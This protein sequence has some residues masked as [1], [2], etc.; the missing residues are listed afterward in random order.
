M[1]S[2]RSIGCHFYLSRIYLFGGDYLQMLS[3]SILVVEGAELLG[4]GIYLYLGYGLRAWAA[5][6]LGKHKEAIQSMQHAQATSQRLGGQLA[7]QDL[8][9]AATAELLLAAGR[10]EEGLTRAEMAVELARVVGSNLSEG[11]AHRVWGQALACLSR[12]EEAERHLKASVQVL[13]SGE[14]LLEAARSQVAWGLLCRD[15]SDPAS[16]Q[17]HFGQAIAQF[18]ASGLTR[19]LEIVRRYLAQMGQS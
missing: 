6:R 19:E 1:K 12:W 10:V 3:E 14:V 9:A 7:F 13:L 2:R 16:A 18:E 4:D 5:S 8:F 15:R 17:E 11:L